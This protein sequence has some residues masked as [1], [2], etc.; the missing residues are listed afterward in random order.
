MS[1]ARV[2]EHVSD[3]STANISPS[4][5]ICLLNR[6]ESLGP[7]LQPSKAV[8]T[9]LYLKPRSLE[10]QSFD[11]FSYFGSI[12]YICLLFT[13]AIAILNE[14]RFLAKSMSSLSPWWHD[15]TGSVLVAAVIIPLI[16]NISMR[17]Y[18]PFCACFFAPSRVVDT[19]PSKRQRRLWSSPKSEHLWR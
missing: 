17:R 18:N 2:E 5:L 19:S 9:S 3:R 14:E 4:L 6:S 16:P 13:N 8:P 11:M 12:L 10:I 15:L 1:A 7:P